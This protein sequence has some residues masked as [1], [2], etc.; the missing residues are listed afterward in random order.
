MYIYR[1]T[2]AKMASEEQIPKLTN[3]QKKRQRQ[4]THKL[5]E[6]EKLEQEEIDRR[7]NLE[8]EKTRRETKIDPKVA[9]EQ[10]DAM[11]E[12][13]KKVWDFLVDRI[14][15]PEKKNQW[16]IKSDKERLN[17]VASLF[18]DFTKTYAVISKYMVLLGNYS[19]I[20]FRRFLKK[21]RENKA[22]I[23]PVGKHDKVAIKAMKKDSQIKWCENNAWYGVYLWEAYAK[24]KN[25]KLRID[26]RA[27]NACYQQCYEPLMG[28]IEEMED[29]K[30][31]AEIMVRERKEKTDR[32]SAADVMNALKNGAYKSLDV[33]AKH[34]LIRVLRQLQLDRDSVS[35]EK[36]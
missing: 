35:S 7:A 33:T 10:D 36:K 29:M 24:A 6:R 12:A 15:T 30:E 19:E 4:K 23:R 20:A 28:E 26:P 5:A 11:C 8:S 18:P 25:P 1:R 22:D 2:L 31:D 3:N 27:R 16:A 34:E 9:K 32:E 14:S 21:S 17:L 13:A